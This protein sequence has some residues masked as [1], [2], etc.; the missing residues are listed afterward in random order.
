MARLAAT[1]PTIAFN[2]LQQL[3]ALGLDLPTIMDQLNGKK[4]EKRG[5]V[6]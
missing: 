3:Q 2:L 6:V 1:G 4:E 5:E